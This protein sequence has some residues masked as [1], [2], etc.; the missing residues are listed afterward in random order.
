MDDVEWMLS[1]AAESLKGYIISLMEGMALEEAAIQ[2]ACDS[3]PVFEPAQMAALN[4]ISSVIYLTAYCQYLDW[5]NH[6]YK[7]HKMMHVNVQSSDSSTQ[8]TS[9]FSLIPTTSSSGAMTS[10]SNA[11]VSS[12]AGLSLDVLPE[13]SAKKLKTQIQPEGNCE[14]SKVKPKKKGKGKGKSCS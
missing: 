5:C 13:C 6:K 8:L 1:D 9:T 7:K 10:P 14:E 12:S 4:S 11:T 3:H 2:S